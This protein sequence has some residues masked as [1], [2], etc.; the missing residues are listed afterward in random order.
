MME[1]MREIHFMFLKDPRWGAYWN[2][3]EAKLAM[4]NRV[5]FFV[6]MVMEH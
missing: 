6:T 3:N 1:G 2:E 4:I 5:I